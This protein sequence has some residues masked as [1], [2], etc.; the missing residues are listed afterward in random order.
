M[1]KK[2]PRRGQVRPYFANLP[3][4]LIELEAW[5]GVI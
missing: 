1:F 3:P 2:A 4:Y 5:G